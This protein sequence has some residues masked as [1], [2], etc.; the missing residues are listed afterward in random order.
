MKAYECYNMRHSLYTKSK[1]L[2]KQ[3]AEAED[4]DTKAW[5]WYEDMTEEEYWACAD[6]ADLRVGETSKEVRRL[7]EAIDEV[8]AAIRHLDRL[9]EHLRYLETEGII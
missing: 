8:E 4:E 6:E 5:K 9:E 3:L 1:V 2:R 7:R